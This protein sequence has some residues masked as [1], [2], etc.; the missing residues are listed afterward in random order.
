MRFLLTIALIIATG[1]TA[2]ACHRRGGKSAKSGGCSAAA[3]AVA[4][5]TPK[6]EAVPVVTVAGCVGGSC[7]APAPRRGSFFRR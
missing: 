7:A 5:V 1:A 4:V 2:E 3:S 6:A